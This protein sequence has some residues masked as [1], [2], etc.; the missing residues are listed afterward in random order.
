MAKAKKRGLTLPFTFAGVGLGIILDKLVELVFIGAGLGFLLDLWRTKGKKGL[1]SIGGVVMYLFGIS[2]I[3]FGTALL[4]SP[5]VGVKIW[6]YAM[7][8]MFLIIAVHYF[9]D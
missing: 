2:F 6:R 9:I 3:A 5:E 4:I 8:A 1:K 7:G